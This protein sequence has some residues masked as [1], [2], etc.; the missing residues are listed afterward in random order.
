MK[1]EQIERAEK[2][3]QRMLDWIARHDTR[4]AAVLGI[5]LAMLGALSSSIPSPSHWTGLYGAALAAAAFGFGFVLAELM[6]G[7]FP[8]FRSTPSLFFFGTVAGLTLQD[9]QRQFDELDENGY[10]EDLLT[11]CHTNSRILRSKFRSL[12]RSIIGLMFT[13]LPW[14]AAL[15]LGK[16]L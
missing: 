5:S 8:R 4:S 3:L 1:R 6:R 12:K 2:T 10:L 9:Y 16:G 7:Q 15:G 14:A 13:A 11:Q